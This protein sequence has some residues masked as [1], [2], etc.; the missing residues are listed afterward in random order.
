MPTT[1][2]FT[3]PP[4]AAPPTAPAAAAPAGLGTGIE[5]GTAAPAGGR[6]PL[7]PALRFR[8]AC[9]E[10]REEPARPAA[11]PPIPALRFLADL[12]HDPEAGWL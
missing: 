10:A 2:L 7:L 11:R 9:L 5:A 8:A 1:L 4:A 3:A 12:P 6:G